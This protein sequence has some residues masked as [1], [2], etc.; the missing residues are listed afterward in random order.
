M[1]PKILFPV[2]LTLAL[3]GCDK[4]MTA[5]PEPPAPPTSGPIPDTGITLREGACF[6]TCPIYAITVYPNEFYELDAGQFTSNPGMSTGTLPA[7]SWAAANQALQTADFQTLPLDVTQ[8][9]PA[10]GSPVA[11]DLPPATITEVTIAGPRIVEWYPGC[12]GA[13][14]RA[15]LNQLVADL[16]VAMTVDA[17]VVP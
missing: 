13:V 5:E 9:S 4:K 17:L 12:F 1:V 6:G 7:G 10:C 16:R 14:D 15:R 11:S 2:L 3:A 8:G